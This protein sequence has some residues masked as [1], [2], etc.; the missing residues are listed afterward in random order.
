MSLPEEVALRSQTLQASCL[1]DPTFT[2]GETEVRGR[3]KFPEQ[4]EPAVFCCTPPLFWPKR[5]TRK[6][7]PGDHLGLGRPKFVQDVVLPEVASVALATGASKN[8][9]RDSSGRSGP[10]SFLVIQQHVDIF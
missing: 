5:T 10:G 8:L 2:L 7:G 9:S 3:N 6:A 4:E 1:K